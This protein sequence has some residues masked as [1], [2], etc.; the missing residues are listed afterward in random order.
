MSTVLFILTASAASWILWTFFLPSRASRQSCV[1]HGSFRRDDATECPDFCLARSVFRPVGMKFSA[2]VS[3]PNSKHMIPTL[4]SRFYTELSYKSVPPDEAHLRSQQ[5]LGGVF[6]FV[7]HNFC[8]GTQHTLD[9]FHSPTNNTTFTM[10][11]YVLKRN[12]KK[13]SVHFDKITSRISKLCYGLD[14]KVR[15]R[16]IT[17][18]ITSSC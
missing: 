10:S 2:F 15:C 3:A 13:E 8:R 14:Q 9:P 17:S 7:S 12:G 6:G 1:G 16:N 4:V 18:Q 11:M 5:K